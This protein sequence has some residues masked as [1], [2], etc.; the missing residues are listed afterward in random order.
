MPKTVNPAPSTPSFSGPADW[1]AHLQVQAEVLDGIDVGLC[2]FD[3][4]DRVVAWNRTFVRMIP[5][6]AGRIRQ[7]EHYA[8]Q[9]RRFYESRL[10]AREAR[11]IDKYIAA[12]VARHQAQSQPF[13][14]DHHGLRLKAA[15][16]PFPGFGRIQVWRALDA[17]PAQAE[18]QADF[19]ADLGAQMLEYVPEA[20]VVSGRDGRIV[21]VNASFCALFGAQER[22]QLLGATIEAAYAAAWD[23]SRDPAHRRRK[24]G[25][26]ALHESL[27]YAGA[28]FELPLPQDRWCRVIARP[29]SDGS[30]FHALIDI[31]ALKRF[32]DALQLTLDNA[33]RGIIHYDADGR[34]LLFNRQALDLLDLPQ[35]LLAGGARILDLVRFQQERGDFLADDPAGRSGDAP[36]AAVD[37]F[38]THSYLRR[39]RAGKVLEIAT[40]ALPHGGAVRTYSDV[41]A[42][43]AAEG[44]LAEKSR[45]LQITLDSMSQGISAIDPTG[46]LVF[47]NRRFQELLQLP[48]ALLA[49]QPTMDE[50][51]RFQAERGDFGPN[52]ELVDATARGFVALGDRL[53]PLRGPQAYVRKTADGRTF[54][55][56]TR[57]LPDGG[58]VRTFTDITAHAAMQE[59]LAHKQAQLAALVS[60]LPD[61]VWV[62][63]VEGRYLLTNPAHQRY[64][65]VPE[66]EVLGRTSEQVFGAERGRHHAAADVRALEAQG[67]VTSEEVDFG[68][69]GEL[70]VAEVVKV[71]MRD[72][73]GQCIGLLGIARDITARKREEAALVKAKEEA[74]LASGAKSRFLSS[75][76]HEIRTPMNAVLGMLT[77]L[78]GTELTPRQDDYAGKAEGAARA[79]LSLLNDILDFSKIE[80]GKMQLD[81][82]PFSLERLLADLSVILSSNVKDRAIEVLYDLDPLVPDGLFGDDMR[83]RQILIN[84]GGNA[85]KF[86]EHGEVVVRTRLASRTESE[87]G[88][89]FSVEDTGIGMSPEQQQRLFSD[90]MQATEETA[91]QFGGT[92]LGLGI[93]RRLTELMGSSL[94]VSSAPG[95]GSRFWFT[96]TLPVV[97][98]PAAREEDDMSTRQRRVLIVD[99]NAVARDTLAALCRGAH[100]L[101]DTAA[102]G[103][104]AVERI[105]ESAARRRSYDAV[106]VDWMMPG[107]DGWQTCDRIRAL[108]LPSR[109]PLVIMVTAQGREMLDERAP[110][111]RALL[112]GFLVKPVTAGMLRKALE[113]VHQAGGPAL[114][115]PAKTAPSPQSLQGIHL[116][117]A[118]DNLVNQQIARE[119]LARHGARVD[120]VD[121]GRAAVQAC[122]A[123]TWYDA[124][125]MDVQMPVL[126]GLS[127]TRELRRTFDA[128]ALPIIAMTANAMDTDRDA[129]LAAGMNDHVPKPFVIEQVIG[130]ILRHVRPG[131]A[132]EEGIAPAAAPAPDALPV[133]DRAGALERL[134]GDEDLLRSVLPV[135]VQNLES[136]RAQLDTAPPAGEELCRLMHSIK[137]MAANVG[138]S[139]LSAAAA[140]AEARLRAAPSTDAHGMVRSLSGAIGDVLQALAAGT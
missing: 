121:N 62:K 56:V 84:L 4:Q 11:H 87:A 69:D 61:R 113:Q 99:D 123:G 90:F 6:H 21:W 16:L 19:T 140:D 47:W 36:E 131:S 53:A 138:A 32:E 68:P 57:P 38:A 66:A 55:V 115:A 65:G 37:I 76:S 105:R 27:R 134:G 132:E 74:L 10:D 110:G 82:R 108:P 94:Q 3:L 78:R 35:E 52:F 129:C 95:V 91:R 7:G 46:R 40:Q 1:L 83:L 17:L 24:E 12:G 114:A 9:L 58:V 49:T 67:P 98:A 44:A 2:A 34:I 43:V 51:V 77:L 25:A 81:R 104:S 15:S 122:L 109:P 26:A 89:E 101:V 107:L 60:N 33:G 128:E 116:L 111:E 29:A 125:L 139:A 50:V 93:C 72:E 70:R 117:V 102:D 28:P 59:A 41:T 22:S 73:T 130:T 106:F 39:T 135:F 23:A 88:I 136:A 13:E 126:D 86:T 127:A 118:E 5:E 96:V 42:Y 85:V 8:D 119:L 137:G 14:F 92:G 18:G 48:G 133:F 103:E 20:L 63:D 54:D 80:A 30:V 31:S 112:D 64:H 79:L 100:W 124:V 71:A 45:A 120:I 75:M 97:Q